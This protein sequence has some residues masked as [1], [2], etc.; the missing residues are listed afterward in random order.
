MLWPW[1][2]EHLDVLA[3]GLDSS[4][5][6]PRAL[7]IL[8]VF[9]RLPSQILPKLARLAVTASPRVRR[10]VQRL[11]STSPAAPIL[12]E[13][14]LKDPSAEIR[15]SA[16]EWLASLAPQQSVDSLRAACATEEDVAVRASMLKAM[17]ACGEDITE[18]LS[19]DQ[20]QQE[21]MEGLEANTQLRRFGI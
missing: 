10:R 14:M 12:A 2:W 21:A 20:L 6:V 9:P 1:V 16:A 3:E 8:E 18:L 7:D 11:L 15:R 19:A 4:E 17:R 5:N 13:P